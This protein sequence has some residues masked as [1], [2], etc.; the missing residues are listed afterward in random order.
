[1]V[2]SWRSLVEGADLVGGV[3]MSFLEAQASELMVR[4]TQSIEETWRRLSAPAPA[5]QRLC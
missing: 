2:V 5:R 1:M 4:P 3:Q